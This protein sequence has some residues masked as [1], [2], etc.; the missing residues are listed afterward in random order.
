[1]PLARRNAVGEGTRM[2]QPGLIECSQRRAYSLRSP[3]ANVIVGQHGD[4]Y[5]GTAHRAGQRLGRSET[6]ITGIRLLSERR[7]QIGND[8]IGAR[9]IVVQPGKQEV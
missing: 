9:K 3:I 2:E 7:L 5:P 4:I 8:E 6:G 1:M